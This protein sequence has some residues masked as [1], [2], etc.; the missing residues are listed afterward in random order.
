[1]EK[2]ADAIPPNSLLALQLCH[3][4]H[5]RG[6]PPLLYV[7]G[8]RTGHIGIYHREGPIRLRP[9]IRTAAVLDL[10]RHRASLGGLP[11]P[12][13]GRS[14][15]RPARDGDTPVGPP[16]CVHNHPVECGPRWEAIHRNIR[17]SEHNP[18]DGTHLQHDLSIVH[19]HRHERHRASLAQGHGERSV[20]AG[21]ERSQGNRPRLRRVAGLV[22]AVFG[23]CGSRDGGIDADLWRDWRTGRCDFRVRVHAWPGAIGYTACSGIN[24][25]FLS[26]RVI[27]SLLRRTK[28]GIC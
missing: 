21:R 19:H 4:M 23:R 25:Q 20:H 27:G 12:Q 14:R 22:L 2:E 5:R 8:R 9:S 11:R 13:G 3:H 26:E 18:G 15:Q 16:E 7:Q 1:M 24:A 28:R 17:L 10:L 6:L